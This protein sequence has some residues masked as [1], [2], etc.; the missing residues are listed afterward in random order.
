MS[1]T[2]Y[3]V[4]RTS[5]PDDVYDAITTYLSCWDTLE[6]A[7]EYGL[8]YRHN[9]IV[10]LEL[11]GGDLLSDDDVEVIDFTEGVSH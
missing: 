9:C 1:E 3:I 4:A 6:E 10:K 2:I 8:D 5:D 11:N 7:K